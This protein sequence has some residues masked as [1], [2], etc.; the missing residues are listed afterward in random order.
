V[1]LAGA[2]LSG[3]TV[4]EVAR[5]EGVTRSHLSREANAPETRLLMADLLAEH[6]EQVQELVAKTLDRI[7]FALDAESVELVVT[8]N[9]RTKAKNGSTKE[10]RDYE[11]QRS[12]VDHFAR[13]TGAKRLIEMIQSAAPQASQPSQAGLITYETFLALYQKVQTPC[14]QP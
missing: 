5:K 1:R 11:I 10:S 6:R 2:L 9:A 12:G 8:K 13:M 7:G 4:T 14:P 3:K